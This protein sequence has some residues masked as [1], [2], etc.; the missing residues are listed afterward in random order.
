MQWLEKFRSKNFEVRTSYG[1]KARCSIGLIFVLT[2]RKLQQ[3]CFIRDFSNV[4]QS[5]GL[6][7]LVKAFTIFTCKTLNLEMS[8]ALIFSFVCSCTK[9][10]ISFIMLG[11]FRS[12][13]KICCCISCK[14]DYFAVVTLSNRSLLYVPIFSTITLGTQMQFIC[15]QTCQPEFFCKHTMDSELIKPWSIFFFIFITLLWKI[16]YYAGKK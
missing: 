14:F 6:G 11:C 15:N 4:F 12:N 7:K 13:E 1:G 3:Y 9:L 2:E 8:P 16:V 5:I 10:H